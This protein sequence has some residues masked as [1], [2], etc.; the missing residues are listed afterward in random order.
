MAFSDQLYL[1]L[2]ACGYPHGAQIFFW[3]WKATFPQRIHKVCV[4]LRRFPNELVPLVC[5]K[6][7]NI[8]L[9]LLTAEKKVVWASNTL[10]IIDKQNLPFLSSFKFD[11][12]FRKGSETAVESYIIHNSVL[13]REAF[14]MF[15][16][17]FWVTHLPLFN[18][19]KRCFL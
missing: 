6:Q 12:L 10:W 2:L 4:L 7:K 1:R 16:I 19:Q 11:R 8:S 17:L 3:I 9:L 5:K 13:K 15:C 18:I 14:F